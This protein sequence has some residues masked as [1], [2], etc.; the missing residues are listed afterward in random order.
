MELRRNNMNTHLVYLI[1]KGKFYTEGKPYKIA[2]TKKDA[3]SYLKNN[4]YIKTRGQ[5][6]Y[7]TI[8]DDYSY[9]ARIEPIEKI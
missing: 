7:E 2:P 8:I 1:I 6:L 9:W 5:P 4:G 3:I